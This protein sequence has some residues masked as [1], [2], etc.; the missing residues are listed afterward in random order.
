M[1]PQGEP[2]RSSFSSSTVA[3]GFAG[4]AIFIFLL[5]FGLNRDLYITI[6]ENREGLAEGS[7]WIEPTSSIHGLAQYISEYPDRTSVLQLPVNGNGPTIAWSPYERRPM[8][9]TSKIVLLLYWADAFTT[10]AVDPEER[11]E[12]EEIRPY[13]IPHIG[14]HRFLEVEQF[15]R[16]RGW[17]ESNGQIVMGDLLRLL[18][19]SNSY[20]LFDYLW[21]RAG[22]ENLEITLERTGMKE[23]DLPLPFSG[24]YLAM[25]ASFQ[26]E[27]SDTNLQRWTGDRSG[28]VEEVIQLASGM[29]VEPRRSELSLKLNRD[30]LGLDFSEERDMLALFPATTP[31]SMAWMLRKLYLNELLG[32]ETDSLVL[33]WMSWPLEEEAINRNFDEYGAIY[34]SRIGLLGGIDFGLAAGSREPVVQ[35]VYFDQVHIAV[36][37]HLSGSHMHQN[38]QQR[39][40]HDPELATTFNRLTHRHE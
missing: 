21:F 35:V 8:G 39:L 15:A 1:N 4:T 22:R 16:S 13:Q 38:F 36:W 3:I 18:A 27:R 7:E 30:R 19:R 10:G 37:F 33:E 9:M 12:W 29:R 6:L 40:M 5:V 11:V 24:L 20:G 26:G 17:L 14:E 31:S 34:D 23:T 32:S 28:F 2:G 25:A